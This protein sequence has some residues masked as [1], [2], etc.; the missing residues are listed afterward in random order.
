[1]PSAYSTFPRSV[2]TG[3]RQLMWSIGEEAPL[4][5]RE[6]SSPPS[7]RLTLL[8]VRPPI[9]CASGCLGSRRAGS[10]VRSI[11]SAAS[12]NPTQGRSPRRR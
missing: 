2:V 11:S 3:V 10:A 1:M 6:R 8:R 4:V 12:A 7:I 5:S 9:W